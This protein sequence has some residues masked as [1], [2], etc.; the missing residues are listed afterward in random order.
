MHYDKE[1]IST[2]II[3]NSLNPAL[4]AHLCICT[5]CRQLYE[6]MRDSYEI[7][8]AEAISTGFTLTPE[9]WI[10]CAA[11]IG[12]NTFEGMPDV[13]R[14]VDDVGREAA[15]TRARDALVDKGLM[16]I[17]FD[18]TV[19]MK[20]Q[21]FEILNICINFTRFLTI[22]RR[23]PNKPERI[24]N[25]YEKDGDSIIMYMDLEKGC[26]AVK[27]AG[28]ML[29]ADI[30]DTKSDNDCDVFTFKELQYLK[31]ET[32]NFNDT[33]N[34]DKTQDALLLAMSGSAGYYSITEIVPNQKGRG[35]IRTGV[36]ISTHESNFTMSYRPDE[37]IYTLSKE[38]E[39]NG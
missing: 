7:F 15:Y 19:G 18:G 9:Q 31:D 1:A 26:T 39:M 13:L 27:R 28:K 2:F 20:K 30:P 33:V 38:C 29:F 10:Y 11:V 4:A 34:Y 21:L 16:E 35:K 24:C 12:G 23:T 22:T 25:I 37:K 32:K 5:E 6:R 3:D 14:H 36:V 17:A 8:G